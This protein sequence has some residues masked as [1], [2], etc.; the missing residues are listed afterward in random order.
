[1]GL[2]NN[3]REHDDTTFAT[4]LADGK[5][6][7]NVPEGT[8]GAV[9]REYETSDGKKG[10]KTE[11][12]YTELSGIIQKISFREGQYGVNLQI[13]VAESEDEK[14]ITMSLGTESNFGEDVMKKLPNI[15]QKLPVTFSPFSFE[16]DKG[17]KQRGVSILQKNKKDEVE[18]VVSFY[19]D[20]DKKVITNGYPE[21]PKPKP[22]K[23]ITK[24][25]WRKYFATV[26]E[27]LIEDLK[28]R[29]DIKDSA[30]EAYQAM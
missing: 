24:S 16:N 7:V 10:S 21:I 3:P 13:V 11:L 27:F 2:K 9:K 14:P 8:E 1:M 23:A 26:R 4:V 29:L 17:K 28:E 30:E 12:V 15:N 5:F 18:K 22:G 6:H 20:A 25:E 19:W